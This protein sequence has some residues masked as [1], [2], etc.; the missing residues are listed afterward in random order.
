VRLKGRRKKRRRLS[1][2]K[3][4]R[5]D[6]RREAQAAWGVGLRNTKE[7][8]LEGKEAHFDGRTIVDKWGGKTGREGGLPEHLSRHD[9]FWEGKNM[10][11]K[12]GGIA[13]LWEKIKKGF[14]RASGKRSF[15]SAPEEKRE[16]K[17]RGAIVRARSP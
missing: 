15:R 10:G 3:N 14:V 16:T 2:L 8:I 6:R 7:K 17:Q 5:E 13:F 12:Q 9:V 11:E 4:F 1:L